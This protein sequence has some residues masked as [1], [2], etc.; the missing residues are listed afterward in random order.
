MEINFRNLIRF[1]GEIRSCIEG[2]ENA[3]SLIRNDQK[4]D[5]NEEKKEREKDRKKERKR[6]REKERKKE[7]R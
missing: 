7:R 3:I 1:R 6:E 2:P 5:E 4:L